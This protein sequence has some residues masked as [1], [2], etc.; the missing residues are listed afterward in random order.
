MSTQITI[1][2]KIKSILPT[3]YFGA[4]NFAKRDIIIE[5]ELDTKYPQVIKLEA[6]KD[7]TSLFDNLTEGQ[8]ATFHINIKGRE[9]T[10]SQGET[11]VFNSIVV[12]KVSDVDSNAVPAPKAKPEPKPNP[13]SD[14]GTLDV[15]V[16]DDLPF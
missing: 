13:L 5:T 9:W 3:Q 8:E 14:A 16:Q 7:N 12:W 4:N 11:Q 6:I 10:N 2:G 1:K 15:T